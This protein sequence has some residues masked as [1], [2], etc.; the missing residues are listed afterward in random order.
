MNLGT[1]FV[2]D[3]DSPYEVVTSPGTTIIT[4]NNEFNHYGFNRDCQVTLTFGKRVIIVFEEFALDTLH[5]HDW[6][7][8]H[9]GDNPDS[10]VIGERLCGDDIPS[11]IESSGNSMTLVFH[12]D[13][14]KYPSEKG[15]KI[16]TNQGT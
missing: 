4:P 10:D 1:V 14:Y 11:P 7:E 3:C 8:V 9:D 12:S 15:F 6:L 13:Q 16:I 5:C 2:I